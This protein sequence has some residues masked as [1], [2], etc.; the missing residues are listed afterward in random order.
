MNIE[1][2]TPLCDEEHRDHSFFSL[3]RLPQMSTPPLPT[4]DCDWN[5]DQR[6]GDFR[7]E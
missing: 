4:I 3:C 2:K 7:K 5:C 1:H 6:D